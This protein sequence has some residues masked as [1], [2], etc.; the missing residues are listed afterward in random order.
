LL[1]AVVE[2]S[3]DALTEW[4]LA[5]QETRHEETYKYLSTDLWEYVPTDRH[6][7]VGDNREE[8]MKKYE[9]RFLSCLCLLAGICL[10]AAATGEGQFLKIDGLNLY[11]EI[12]GTGEP[13]LYLHGGLS[14]SRDFDAYVPVLSRSFKVILIDRRGHG[15]S[16][17]N[18]RPYDYASM[19]AEMNRCLEKLEIDSAYVVGW[20]DGGVVGY[21]LAS[22]YP[23]RV[24]KLV[25]IGAN[26]RVAGMSTE[27]L[28][29]L[30]ANHTADALKK[31][32]P[33]LETQ[34][35]KEN[36]DPAN[37]EAFLTRSR[38]LWLRDPYISKEEFS[39][40]GVPVLLVAGDRDDIR[41]EHM[42]EMKGL[43][44]NAQLCIVPKASHF[45]IAERSELFLNVLR[46]FLKP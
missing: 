31:Q 5:R 45:L 35:R 13:L 44:K 3:P 32:L 33:E 34:Y 43:L 25:T 26:Y 8:R 6:E 17:D 14:S 21:H 42:V 15:R 11:C 4:G 12:V 18:G 19:A 9:T 40:I 20:S 27:A 16:E 7:F 46:Q 2:K 23:H 37:F 30:A 29:W 1:D 39:R 36:P 28:E 22:K 38:D 24:K 10:S 41:L